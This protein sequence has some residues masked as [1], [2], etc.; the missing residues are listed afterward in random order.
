MPLSREIGYAVGVGTSAAGL[1]LVVCRVKQWMDAIAFWDEVRL[2]KEKTMEDE[3]HQAEEKMKDAAKFQLETVWTVDLKFRGGFKG[4]RERLESRLE[5]IIS[6]L[7]TSR[8]ARSEKDAAALERVV[9]RFWNGR[10]FKI[11]HY[12]DGGC[13]GENKYPPEEVDDSNPD[14]W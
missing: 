10:I 2:A 6:T 11:P 7:R 12:G 9:Q 8:S 3:V 5:W 4:E 1:I 13:F 14:N